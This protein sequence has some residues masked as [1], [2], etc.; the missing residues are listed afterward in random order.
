MP[1]H[2]VLAATRGDL[3]LTGGRAAIGDGRFV[4]A[5]TLTTVTGKDDRCRPTLEAMVHDPAAGRVF[6]ASIT[7]LEDGLQIPTPGYPDDAAFEAWV[8]RHGEVAN[9]LTKAREA[10]RRAIA[11]GVVVPRPREA[12]YDTASRVPAAA[13]GGDDNA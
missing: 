11:S 5:A 10:V 6:R 12:V 4:S 7:Y 3:N 8:D 13:E 1:S 2:N 9:R